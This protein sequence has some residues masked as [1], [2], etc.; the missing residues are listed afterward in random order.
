M[1]LIKAR[2]YITL[3]G[4]HYVKGTYQEAQK[5]IEK[6]L[7]ICQDETN[8]SYE[9]AADFKKNLKELQT[10]QLRCEGRIKGVSAHELKPDAERIE[11]PK[12]H[13]HHAAVAPNANLLPML[14]VF[15]GFST[16]A[17]LVSSLLMRK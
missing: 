14:F 13:P 9:T 17:F 11:V 12:H 6:A 1:Q 5:A 15:G 7:A 2:Y 4:I 16:T 10:M 3:A 8:Y